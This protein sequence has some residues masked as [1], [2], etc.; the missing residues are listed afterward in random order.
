MLLGTM[1]KTKFALLPMGFEQFYEFQNM[2]YPW[3]FQDIG[4]TVWH[5]WMWFLCDLFQILMI[6]YDPA[7]VTW[8]WP[9]V[10]GEA[11]E[12]MVR[13]FW[14]WVYTEN[15]RGL[16][17]SSEGY[18]GEKLETDINPL[19]RTCWSERDVGAE[20]FVE[21]IVVRFYFYPF[22]LLIWTLSRMQFF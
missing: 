21:D 3:T 12:F 13:V 22:V 14:D 8:P 5:F 15:T 2:T 11:N 7:G 1:S 19:L 18:D 9:W 20:V 17:G 6:K 10:T 16:N 4:R